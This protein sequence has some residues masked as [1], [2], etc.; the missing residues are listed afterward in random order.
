MCTTLGT[1]FNQELGTGVML[2][3]KELE[4]KEDVFLF[5][6]ANA[7]LCKKQSR[8]SMLHSCTMSLN[9]A[10]ENGET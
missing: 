7:L 10:T 1:N 8:V 3:H 4:E 9:P 6:C 2:R 5:E